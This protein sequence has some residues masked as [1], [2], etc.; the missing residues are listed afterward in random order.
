MFLEKSAGTHLVKADVIPTA[1]KKAEAP[2]PKHTLV[3]KKAEYGLFPGMEVPPARKVTA[4]NLSLTPKALARS[5]AEFT[6]SRPPKA[7]PAMPP[8]TMRRE[9]QTGCSLA[10]SSSE[11]VSFF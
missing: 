7:S 4:M 1:E 2:K 11:G 6:N 9:S 3:I 5:V 8:A 10:V